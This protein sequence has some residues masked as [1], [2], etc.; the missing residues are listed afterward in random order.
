MSDA[1]CRRTRLGASKKVTQRVNP[2]AMATAPTNISLGTIAA[3]MKP[4][5]TAPATS[6]PNCKAID[7]GNICAVTE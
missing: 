3:G 5:T 1:T 6:N 7:R 4:S 2:S